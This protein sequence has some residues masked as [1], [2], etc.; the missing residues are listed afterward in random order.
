MQVDSSLRQF[1]DKYQIENRV[2]A[3]GVSG[4]ADSLALVLRLQEELAPLG[5]KVVALTVD[6]GLRTE[7][8]AEAEYV[9]GLMSERGIEHHIL[10]WKG[11]KPSVGIEE[12]A[13]KARYGLLQEWCLANDV[14]VLAMAHHGGDQAE[15]FF[16][17]LQRGSG[18]FGLCGM[19]PVSRYENLTIIRP[20]LDCSASMLK[21]YLRGHGIIW[22]EDPSNQCED[23]LRVKIR[24]RLPRWLEEMNLPPERLLGT[25]RELARARDYIQSRTDSFIKNHV[26][27]WDS[28]GV[29]FSL[30]VLAAQHSEIVFQVL[31]QLVRKV[32]GRIYIPRAEDVERL[33]IR[34]VPTFQNA[35]TLTAESEKDFVGATLGGCEIFIKSGKVWIV[36]ELKLVRPL[37]RQLWVDFCAAYPEYERLKLP[38]KMRAAL[39]KTKM[40]VEF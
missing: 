22:V 33:A 9:A 21:E 2:I 18:L 1:F 13:R 38:Y 5:R 37:P 16:L 27:V 19:L 7:S 26:R 10:V 30:S 29:S 15:T 4:G 28:S 12:A 3:A 34:L 24:K 32:G 39:V 20:L 36:P 11:E 25:M 14:G 23:Y 40:K 17:R 6:H 31:A 35:K 8:R